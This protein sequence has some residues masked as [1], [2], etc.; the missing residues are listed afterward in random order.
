VKKETRGRKP[1]FLEVDSVHGVQRVVRCYFEYTTSMAECECVDCKRI[2]QRRCNALRG[3]GANSC[4]CNRKGGVKQADVKKAR[5]I[6]KGL[7]EGRKL[8]SL[9]NELCISRQAVHW[10]TRYMNRRVI[11]EW[12]D[13][14][15]FEE[16]AT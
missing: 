7:N 13:P 6:F 14:E 10:Y 16:G 4:V 8:Q 11:Y 2:T 3:G 9:A 15:R 12:K 1:M 5:F